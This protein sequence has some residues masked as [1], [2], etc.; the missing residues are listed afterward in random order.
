ME[1][2]EPLDGDDLSRG[3]S[4]GGGFERRSTA[5]QAFA[6]RTPQFELRPAIRAGVGLGVESPV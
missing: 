5:L 2:T 4:D 1:T 6:P 3:K